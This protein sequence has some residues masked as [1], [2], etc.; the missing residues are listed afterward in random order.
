M[1][2][3]PPTED[4]LSRLYYELGKIGARSAGEKK[5]WPRHPSS[6]EELFILASDWSRFDPRLLEILVQFGITHRE[7]LNPQHL[8]TLSKAMEVPQTLGVIASFIQTA[9]PDDT[10]LNL[11]WRYVTERLKPVDLQFYF[12]DLYSPASTLSERAAKE[13]LSEFKKWGFLGR[14]RI[15]IDPASKTTVG[16]MDA[17]SRLNVLKRLFA[18]Q[19]KIQISDYL[20]AIGHTVSRQQALLDLKQTNATQQ[21]KGRSAF[22][23]L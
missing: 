12:R 14:E 22:W 19:K 11:F 3:A 7:K 4:H 17:A 15:I 13:G 21:G 9:K 20:K 2:T 18:Q 23:I 10:E 8:R 6:P 5:K 16:T 1:K